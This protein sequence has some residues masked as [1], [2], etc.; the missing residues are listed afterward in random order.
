LEQTGNLE[1]GDS[2][3]MIDDLI[4]LE[5]DDFSKLSKNIETSVMAILDYISKISKRLNLN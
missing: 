5:S 3:I 4:I 2:K 1:N